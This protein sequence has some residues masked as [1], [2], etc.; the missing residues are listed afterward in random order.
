MKLKEMINNT[1]TTNGGIFTII[2]S[3]V[4]DYLEDNKGVDIMV[5]FLTDYVA[6]SFLKEE[7]LNA[8]VIAYSAKTHDDGNM[9]EFIFQITFPSKEN[10]DE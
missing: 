7:I 8:N 1:A 4:H 9:V 2:T 5:S 10:N 6:E 3:S